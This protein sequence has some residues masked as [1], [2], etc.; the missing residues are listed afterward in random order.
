MNMYGLIQAKGGRVTMA[1]VENSFDGNACRCTGYR[2]ILDA[3]KSLA[4]DADRTLLERCADIEDLGKIC[5]KSRQS[6]GW[7]RCGDESKE[8]DDNRPIRL[9]FSDEMQREWHKVV[10]LRELFECLNGERAD[11]KEYQ[12]AAGNTGNG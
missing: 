4:S 12:L 9:K 10:T 8:L 5:T 1:D 11:G 7:S 6:S 2:P 3:F